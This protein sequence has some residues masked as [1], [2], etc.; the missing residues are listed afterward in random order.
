MSS[1]THGHT[2]TQT[3]A[4]KHWGDSCL[5]H[6][7]PRS[8]FLKSALRIKKKCLCFRDFLK[9]ILDIMQEWAF[10][11]C[12]PVVFTCRRLPTFFIGAEPDRR[13]HVLHDA[14]PVGVSKWQKN[15]Q[16]AEPE[17][18]RGTNRMQG[19]VRCATVCVGGRVRG[20]IPPQHPGTLA[21]NK[22]RPFLVGSQR[23]LL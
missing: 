8:H 3:R 19:G 15:R 22:S 10:I 11:C 1:S 4:V 2:E 18:W 13:G 21:S 16:S 12:N 23:H 5:L 20:R 9:I 7:E 14:A 17:D 6:E